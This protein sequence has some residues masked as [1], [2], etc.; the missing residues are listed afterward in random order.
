MKFVRLFRRG[1]STATPAHSIAPAYPAFY[2]REIAN[3]RTSRDIQRID[4]AA[5][6]DSGLS[7]VQ[8]TR[9]H[10]DAV[11]AYLRAVNA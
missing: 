3:V 9:I 11:A 1:D 8:V 4:H 7:F 5:E 6:T 2:R 10:N